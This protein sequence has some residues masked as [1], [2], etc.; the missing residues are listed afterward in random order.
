M[1]SVVGYDLSA[2]NATKGQKASLL[3]EIE[4]MSKAMDG[5]DPSTHLNVICMRAC[6]SLSEP[7]C[8]VMEYVPNGKLLDLLRG[9][10]NQVRIRDC[11]RKSV[12]LHPLVYF[13]ILF[14]GL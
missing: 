10:R 2:E 8:L 7:Y 13:M 11:A 12:F 14:T 3:G 6:V 5:Y 1:V 4:L 9:A